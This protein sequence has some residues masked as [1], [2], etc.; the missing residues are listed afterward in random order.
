[1]GAYSEHRRWW[2]AADEAPRDLNERLPAHHCA[3]YAGIF[4]SEDSKQLLRTRSGPCK[5]V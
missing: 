1:M 3:L 4:L 5:A 2:P